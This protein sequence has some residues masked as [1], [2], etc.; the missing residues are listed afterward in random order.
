MHLTPLNYA[1][2]LVVT[3]FEVIVCALAYWFGLYRTLPFFTGFLTVL[4]AQT[5]FLWVVYRKFGFGSWAAYDA[6]WGANALMLVAQALVIGE[7]CYCLLRAYPGIW[8]LARLILVAVAFLFVLNAALVAA[9]RTYWL[10]TFVLRLDRDLN[11]ASV[12]VLVTLLLIG[13][14]YQLE[15]DPLERRVAAGLCVWS[16]VMTITNAFM[17]QAAATH[18]PSWHGYYYWLNQIYT[19]WYS[20]RAIPVL[21]VLIAWALA[22]RQPVPA[23]RPAPVLLPASAYG[24]LS[25]DVNLR[26]RALNMRLMELLKP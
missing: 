26:L 20:A 2:W 3:S 13:R 19:W 11:L 21:C 17:A 6:A 9:Y 15:L 7:L 23:A 8:A 5:G 10:D 14:Y 1:L 12:G 25:P 4:V 18:L 22:L 24:D 16:V